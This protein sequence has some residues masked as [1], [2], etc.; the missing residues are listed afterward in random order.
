MG[1]GGAI[2]HSGHP[3]EGCYEFALGQENPDIVPN[4]G[5]GDAAPYDVQNA[6]AAP[7][8]TESRFSSILTKERGEFL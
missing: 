1:R 4:V 8:L 6:P 5:V 7:A 3:G 2:F